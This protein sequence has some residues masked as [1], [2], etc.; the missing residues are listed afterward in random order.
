MAYHAFK[1][2]DGETFG[3]F[4]TF[5][6]NTPGDCLAMRADEPGAEIPPIGSWFWWACS[7][8]CMPD[9]EP[10]GPFETEEQAIEDA[11]S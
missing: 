7:P 6:A 9:G 5:Q 8:G 4:E 3:S 1:G 11:N 2:P 10:V